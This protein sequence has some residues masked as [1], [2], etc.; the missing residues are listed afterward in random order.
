M[1]DVRDRKSTLQRKSSREEMR[2][3]L[4]QLQQN[5]HK[6]CPGKQFLSR[7]DM[8]KC[9]VT[10][11]DF[12]FDRIFSLLDVN[13][14]GKVHVQILL[15]EMAN[16]ADSNNK[17]NEWL[18]ADFLFRVLDADASGALS[19][20]E[21]SEAIDHGLSGSNLTAIANAQTRTVIVDA[22]F[23][24]C[25]NGSNDISRQVFCEAV[26]ELGLTYALQD[27]FRFAARVSSTGKDRD[28]QVSRKVENTGQS[29]EGLMRL[30]PHREK[31]FV[32]VF[33]AM[34][35]VAFAITFAAYRQRDA[36][37]AIMG[38]GI[39]GARGFAMPLL[40]HIPW[41]SAIDF[42]KIV[43]GT[44]LVNSLGHTLCHFINFANFSVSPRVLWNAS[45]LSE[46][47]GMPFEPTFLNY[48]TTVPGCTGL[49][50]LTIMAIAYPFT[51]STIRNKSFNKFWITHN[52]FY[53]WIFALLIHGTRSIFEPSTAWAWVSV[54]VLG[55]TAERFVRFCS[56]KR[57]TY[58]TKGIVRS[59]AVELEMAKPL[60]FHYV[61][62]QYVFIRIPALSG[63]EWHPFTLSSSPLSDHLSLHIRNAGDW[64]GA[65]MELME[66]RN[67]NPL[68]LRTLL[69][70][71]LDGPYGAP[72]Q[73]Y[74]CYRSIIMIGAGI[75]ITPFAS[76]LKTIVHEWNHS[77]SQKK[78]KKRRISYA[79]SLDNGS[80]SDLKRVHLH[81]CVRDATWLPWFKDTMSAIGELD[82]EQ[83]VDMKLYL[84]SALN[85]KK[86]PLEATL[87]QLGQNL[88][89][90]DG[91]DIISSIQNQRF[92]TSMGR[93]N[94]ADVFQGVADE[95]QSGDT[96]GCFF[97]GPHR[98]GL[99][100]KEEA[101]KA[102][103]KT[104][105]KFVVRAER[106]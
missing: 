88:V 21:F 14:E 45:V 106:F 43:G 98:L 99:I 94:W 23:D 3:G 28:E 11:S 42:H 9:I 29:K 93:P 37:F 74:H 76:I 24:K 81:W 73:D 82:H 46:R 26:I 90:Q 92:L 89:H 71:H 79:A 95:S 17:D 67:S 33:F 105:V 66:V 101:A 34:N 80:V 86:A 52:L 7:E 64:T 78:Q 38:W 57:H 87:I 12:F 22:V 47:S 55:F 51:H 32:I 16:L 61:A 59:G 100:L 56:P 77:R 102:T 20:E 48:A 36:E 39:C 54:P 68:N 50:M 49:A 13:G 6:F 63:F 97:C 85:T 60:G 2:S 65:L 31:A 4:R 70:V 96:V 104:G 30:L 1:E 19:R 18:H 5:L 103:M 72:A 84:T 27:I 69:Q 91:L 44:I 83:R 15:A 25:G 41:D 53:L 35:I 8:K 75:G 40:K 58:V 62:G 10:K